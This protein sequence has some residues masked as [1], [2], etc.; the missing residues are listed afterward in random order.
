MENYEI[1]SVWSPNNKNSIR[2]GLLIHYQGHKKSTLYYNAIIILYYSL[3]LVVGLQLIIIIGG[4]WVLLYSTYFQNDKGIHND[5]H[6]SM[7]MPSWSLVDFD[8]LQLVPTSPG[9]KEDNRR[10]LYLLKFSLTLGVFFNLL[11]YKTVSFLALF[12][13]TLRSATPFYKLS[14]LF[15]PR[16][17]I[18]IFIN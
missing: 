1:K 15:S 16:S 9:P 6:S 4:L 13:L 7:T 14:A 12:L 5:I 17:C 2:F 18:Y 3:L 8:D 10:A 11:L